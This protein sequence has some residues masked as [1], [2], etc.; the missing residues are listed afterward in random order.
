MKTLKVSGF[1]LV[2]LAYLQL[3]LPRQGKGHT[4][5]SVLN[6]LIK[7]MYW[8][9]VLQLPHTSALFMLLLCSLPLLTTFLFSIGW[10]CQCLVM[11]IL[12][13]VH[14][15]VLVL[16]RGITAMKEAPKD[17]DI[18][19]EVL[20]WY[21]YSTMLSLCQVFDSLKLWYLYFGLANYTF[22]LSW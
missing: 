22:L 19:S 8:G 15:F 4:I 20:V 10:S 7:K 17:K 11:K 12:F 2:F 14:H 21:Q 1:V 3:L 9:L 18:S 6:V 5:M 16:V 13:L